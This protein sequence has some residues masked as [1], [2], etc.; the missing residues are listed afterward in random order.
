MAEKKLRAVFYARVSTEEEMQ[1]NALEKQIAE[2]ISV[3]EENGWELADKYIDEG[4]SGTKTKGRKEYNRLFEDMTEGKFDVIVI[5]SQ[6]R[7]MRNT[8]DWYLFLDRLVN[9][10]LQL[11]MYLDNNFYTPEDKF[12][13]GIKAQ[14]AEE[15]S[16]DLSK[17][18]NNANK[19]RV[20]R[21]LKG[22]PLSAMGNGKSLGF[23]I[24]DG[25]WVQV[26]EEIEV[27]KLI[28][29]LYEKYDSLRKVRD[30]I[31]DKGYRNSVGKPFTT[32][33]ISRI[34]KNEKAKGVI[35]LGKYHHDF[36]KKKIVKRED[37]E[38]VRVPAPELA[39]VSEERFDK[40]QE[41]LQAKTGKG[42]GKNIGRDI[43][44]G[45]LYCSKCGGVLWRRETVRTNKDGEKKKYYHWVCSNKYAKGDIICE[46]TGTTTAKITKIYKELTKDIVVNKTVVKKDMIEWLNSLKATLSDTTINAEIEK[47]IEK[48]E[49]KRAKLLDAYLEELISKEDYTVRYKDVEQMIKEKEKLLVPVE[50]NEDIKEIEDTI[51]NIDREIDN[52][53]ST[54]D[55]DNNKVEWLLEQTK[56]ITVL[57]NKDLVIELEMIAGAILAGKDFLLYVHESMPYCVQMTNGTKVYLKVA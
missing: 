5:K 26:P 49:R 1:L 30:E 51:T 10:D 9:N 45:K 24:E 47:D 18:L 42:R 46:G 39:Y 32:E 20:E 40:V 38:V 13:T 22:E 37:E 33:S 52:W 16:R 12:I 41:R 14:M 25:K 55:F 27:C 57:E 44:S 31:N 11:F 35:V 53:L 6:D 28:W 17:K 2:N 50:E 48:L 19:R 15:Y 8:L 23:A 43:L 56:K 54:T 29:D 34:L 36:E 7:L 21:A 4:K 3:I